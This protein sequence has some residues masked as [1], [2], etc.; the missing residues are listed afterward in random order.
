MFARS[1]CILLPSPWERGRG[2]GFFLP[3][4][5]R[6]W[7]WAFGVG[8]GDRLLLHLPCIGFGISW[9]PDRGRSSTLGAQEVTVLLSWMSIYDPCTLIVFPISSLLFFTR[10]PGFLYLFKNYLGISKLL[11]QQ[12]DLGAWIVSGIID[13]P[14]MLIA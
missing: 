7:E 14:F 1:I 9:T 13:I 10:F 4:L 5:W 3:L 8:L 11:N 6:G 2:R 12:I